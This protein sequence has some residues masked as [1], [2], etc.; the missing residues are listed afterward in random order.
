MF[1]IHFYVNISQVKNTL[2][3]FKMRIDLHIVLNLFSSFDQVY[4][5]LFMNENRSIASNN[6]FYN[7]DIKGQ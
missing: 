4:I 1:I 2:Y 3:I 6:E 7:I 5:T